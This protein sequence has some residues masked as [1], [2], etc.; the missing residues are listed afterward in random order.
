MYDISPKNTFDPIL[1]NIAIPILASNS[2]GVIY[3]SNAISKTNKHRA[4]AIIT[5]IAISE[6]AKSLV[7]INVA[8]IPLILHLLSVI[9]LNFSTVSIVASE[10]IASLKVTSISVLPSL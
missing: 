2:I 3:E 6:F 10:E 4:T 5:Y 9:S 1:N 7:S 8:V